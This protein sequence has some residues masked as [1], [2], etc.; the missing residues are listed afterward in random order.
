MVPWFPGSLRE[1]ILAERLGG[2]ETAATE[3][4]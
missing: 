3:G 4:L 1:G 2:T